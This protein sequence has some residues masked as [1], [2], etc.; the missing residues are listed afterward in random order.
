MKAYWKFAVTP[1]TALIFSI[2]LGSQALAWWPFGGSDIQRG[3]GDIKLGMSE[4]EVKGKL[5]SAGSKPEDIAKIDAV[6]DQEIN[7]QKRSTST[8]SDT[9]VASKMRIPYEAVK[10]LGLHGIT[11]QGIDFLFAKNSLIYIRSVMPLGTENAKVCDMMEKTYTKFLKN[12]QDYG[13]GLDIVKERLYS[14]GITD[15]ITIVRPFG[16]MNTMGFRNKMVQIIVYDIK[17][18]NEIAK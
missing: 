7:W 9:S 16:Q 14:D 13:N 8:E 18:I 17:N 3:Y 6:D 15:V 1:V 11:C 10:T 4:E 5:K 12:K 2:I